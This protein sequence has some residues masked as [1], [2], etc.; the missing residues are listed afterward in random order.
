MINRF[1]GMALYLGIGTFGMI[2]LGLMRAKKYNINPF[3][4][5]V[6]MLLLTIFGV[7]G[8]MTMYY[9]ENGSWGGQSYFGAVLITPLLLFPIALLFKVPYFEFIS[10]CAPAECF[11][12]AIMKFYCI[13][14]GCCFGKVHMPIFQIIPLQLI[15]A[16]VG[17]IVMILLVKMEKENDLKEGY[18]RYLVLY[19]AT[20]FCLN[21]F[22]S[23]IEIF[24]IGLTAGHFWGLVS[25]IIGMFWLILK[26]KKLF[27]F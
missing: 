7:L 24:L 27:N 10:Y 11:M 21:Y 23:S 20:R 12:L 8:V 25:V 4:A 16:I 15:E 19:G 9:I 2:I 26:K 13:K 14:Q 22:R 3:K 6:S 17:I 1:M 5:V 18:A